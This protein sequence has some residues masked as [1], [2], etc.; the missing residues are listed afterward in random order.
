MILTAYRLSDKK[1]IRK[2][3][4]FYEAEFYLKEQSFE[5][6]PVFSGLFYPRKFLTETVIA[7][8]NDIVIIKKGCREYVV[9]DGRDVYPLIPATKGILQKILNFLRKVR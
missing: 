5:N 3:H 7:A 2:F 8:E 6:K 1:V 9:K 4:N